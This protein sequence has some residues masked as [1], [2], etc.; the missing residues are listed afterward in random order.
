MPLNPLKIVDILVKYLQY[1]FKNIHIASLDSL[2][3]VSHVSTFTGKHFYIM[4]FS[5]KSPLYSGA[6]LHYV[7]GPNPTL[8]PSDILF[9][10]NV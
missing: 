10:Q 7:T 9:I 4:G 3:L 2:F 8:S 1:Y 5:N 6:V